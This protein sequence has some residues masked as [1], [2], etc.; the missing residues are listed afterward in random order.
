M[1][2]AQ[3]DRAE[4]EALAQQQAAAMRDVLAW[5]AE[6]PGRAAVSGPGVEGEAGLLSREGDLHV[7]HSYPRGDEPV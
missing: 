5:V 2:E 1:I 3:E 4:A 7:P 6:H